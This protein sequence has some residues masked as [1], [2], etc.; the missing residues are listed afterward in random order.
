MTFFSYFDCFSDDPG[1]FLPELDTAS[2]DPMLDSQVFLPDL[3]PEMS[4]VEMMDEGDDGV[5]DGAGWSYRNDTAGV[6]VV[7]DTS[8]TDWQDMVWVDWT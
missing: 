3:L 6:G 4:L 7:M 1:L 8:A 2:Y 5:D